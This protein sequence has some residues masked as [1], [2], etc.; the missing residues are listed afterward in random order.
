MAWQVATLD[1]AKPD[2]CLAR[3]KSNTWVGWLFV[4]G[5]V[6]EMVLVNVGRVP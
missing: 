4:A 6:A 2:N 1:I 5:L 3:F